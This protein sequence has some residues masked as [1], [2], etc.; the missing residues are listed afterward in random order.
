MDCDCV[1]CTCPESSSSACTCL[2][3]CGGDSESAPS[4]LAIECGECVVLTAGPILFDPSL[5]NRPTPDEL[6]DWKIQGLLADG[7]QPPQ[8]SLQYDPVS[9]EILELRSRVT[10]DSIDGGVAGPAWSEALWDVARINE[11]AIFLSALDALTS[12]EVAPV[13]WFVQEP[14]ALTLPPAREVRLASLQRAADQLEAAAE[15]LRQA[16]SPHQ[17]DIARALAEAVRQATAGQTESGGETPEP[18]RR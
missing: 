10:Q 18:L 6:L 8:G 7:G 16:E 14:A 11:N 4:L 9:L 5:N 17:A 3:C 2:D 15:T 12:Q 13:G 1:D